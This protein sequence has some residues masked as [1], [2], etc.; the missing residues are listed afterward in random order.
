MEVSILS[1]DA[2]EI[3]DGLFAKFVGG[4]LSW[5]D[6][7]TGK[8]ILEL[9]RKDMADYGGEGVYYIF[10]VY[11]QNMSTEE[12]RRKL[13]DLG[14]PIIKFLAG[15]MEI[16]LYDFDEITERSEEAMVKLLR[17]EA[18]IE[19][20]KVDVKIEVMDQGTGNL[21][22]LTVGVSAH[23]TVTRVSPR[24][25]P[26]TRHRD[27]GLAGDRPGQARGGGLSV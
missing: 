25:G 5:G 20:K 14:L 11:E 26:R 17:E 15:R 22:T 2:T 8:P 24:G 3:Y 21:H 6:P 13:L 19:S 9:K 7:D 16:P 23:R 4:S 27:R 1:E 12:T 10:K 18:D